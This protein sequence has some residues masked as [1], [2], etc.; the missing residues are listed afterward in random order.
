MSQKQWSNEAGSDPV[1]GTGA[2][3]QKLLKDQ[4]QKQDNSVFLLLQKLLI[5][6]LLLLLQVL[7]LSQVLLLLHVVIDRRSCIAEDMG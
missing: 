6:L 1:I 2:P 3:H 4:N 5:L 7:L